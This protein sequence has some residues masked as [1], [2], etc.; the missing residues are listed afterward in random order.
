MDLFVADAET[1][2]CYRFLILNEYISQRAA[3][4]ERDK[5]VNKLLYVRCNIY[6]FFFFSFL[7]FR[8]SAHVFE[9][10]SVIRHRKVLNSGQRWCFERQTL[11]LWPSGRVRVLQGGG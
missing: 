9:K 10:R 5:S 4:I 2:Y 6:V 3:M 1:T 8:K 7:C 11:A